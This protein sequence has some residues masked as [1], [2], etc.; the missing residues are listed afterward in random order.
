MYFG[1]DYNAEQWPEA[2]WDEDVALMRDA[3]VNLVSVGIFSWAHLQPEEGV[4]EF[5]WLDR[6]LDKLHEN[7]IGVDLATAT[8]SPPAWMIAKYPNILPV[9]EDG[10]RLGFGSRQHYSATSADYRRL[11]A[12]LVTELGQRYGHHPAVQMWHVN[13]EYGCHVNADFSDSASAAFRSWLRDRYVTVEAV[14]DAWSTNFWSQRYSSF[15]QIDP[16]RTSPTTQNPSLVLDFRRFSSDSLLEL[17]VM[18]RDILRA[19]GVTTPIVTNFMGP[20]RHLDYWKWAAATDIVTDDNYPDPRDPEA[21]RDA[22]LSRDLMRSLKPGIPWM[23]MEQTSRS[24]QWRPNN[25]AKAPGQMAAWSEQAVARGAEGIMFFQWRQSRG[26]Q[27]KFH[28]AMLPQAG[29][30][31]PIWGEIVK[32]GGDLAGRATTKPERGDI[33]I[34]LD[35]EN[36]WALDQPDLPADVDYLAEITLWYRALH[37]QHHQVSFVRAADD[38]S[39]FRVVIAPALYVLTGEGAASLREFVAAGGIL[40]SSAFF[41]IVDEHDRFR[42]GGYTTQLADVVGGQP[43]DFTGVL[44]EDGHHISVGDERS[45]PRVMLEELAVDAG[46]VLLHTNRNDPVLLKNGYGDG[47][48]LHLATFPDHALAKHVIDLAVRIS[49]TLPVYA[50]LPES[51]EAIA[52]DSASVLIN[53]S[54]HQTLVRLSERTVS[55]EPFEVFRDGEA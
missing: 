8:A 49:G 43:L 27:E 35:W 13:N 46:H 3:G 21:F 52:T 30:R 24:V 14:N 39:G 33:A 51:V 47:T 48:S 22:A 41:D 12:D 31:S 54:E 38:L 44:P 53:H 28:S 2:T 16:P 42:A 19:A 40:V 1:G 55:L 20:F 15:D 36:W 6:L 25:A 26:G 29:T 23:L 45:V 11:A 10:I 37:R 9:T 50:D 32:L 5:G 34:V 7:G 18:E 17:F 4:F